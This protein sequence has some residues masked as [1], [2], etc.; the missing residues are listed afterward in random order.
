MMCSNQ[1]EGGALTARRRSFDSMM[2]GKKTSDEG[3]K[4]FGEIKLWRLWFRETDNKHG[5]QIGQCCLYS[6]EGLVCLVANKEP[7]KKAKAC[8]KKTKNARKQKR[9]KKKT[10]RKKRVSNSDAPNESVLLGESSQLPGHEAYSDYSTEE[11]ATRKL[12]AHYCRLRWARHRAQGLDTSWGT[13][14]VCNS[15]S[16]NGKLCATHWVPELSR[17]PIESR[18]WR[19]HFSTHSLG[20]VWGLPSS[21]DIPLLDGI[22]TRSTIEY[23]IVKNNDVVNQPAFRSSRAIHFVLTSPNEGSLVTAL[24]GPIK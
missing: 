15:N 10:A 1:Q 16:K 11:W 2:R 22:G 3:W 4:S 9:T 6:N 5:Y 12:A 20:S 17:D 8:A 7:A 13:R 23:R 19:G 21:R 18:V 24:I 14:L